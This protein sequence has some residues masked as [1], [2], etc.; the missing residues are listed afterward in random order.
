MT[1]PAR[2]RALLQRIFFWHGQGHAASSE[3]VP[4]PA[5]DHALVLAARPQPAVPKWRQLRYVTRVLNLKERRLLVAMAA[6]F[7]VAVVS[8][9]WLLVQTRMVAT[10]APGGRI[11][12]AIIGAPK[13]PHPFYASTN[14]PDQDLV[15]LV[16]AGLFRRVGGS[17]VEPDLAERFEWSDGGKKLTV[18]LR[19]DAR[20]HDGA[21]LTTDDVLFTLAAA[22]D[23]AWRS[24]FVN[25]LRTMTME[26][27]DDRTLTLTFD[28]ADT[29]ILDT[30]TLGILPA[31]IWQD[32][33]PGSAHLADAN[34]RPIGAGP[35]RVRSFLKDGR[36]TIL[37]YT[38]ERNTQYH[39]LKAYLDQIELRFFPS[40]AEAEEALR[41]GQVDTLAFVPGPS[42]EDLTKH[43]RLDASVLELPQE[44]IA[45]LNVND[46]LLKEPKIRQAL[47]LVTE[48]DEIVTAQA[49]ISSPVNGP[50]PFLAFSA[51]SST[52][53]ERLEHARGLLE[54][55][56]W[57][58]VEGR[59][60]RVRSSSSTSTADLP[61][62]TFT[63]T[64]PDVPDLVAVSETLKRRWGLLSANVN[65]QVEPAEP[66]ARRVTADR[67]AQILVWNVL[68][69]PSQDQYPVWWSGEATGRGLNLSNLADRNVDDAIEAIRAATTTEMLETA[70]AA[71][72]QT[73]L[74]RFPAVF[75]TRPGYGYVHNTRLKGMTDRLQLGRPSDRFND[76]V[77]WYV[78]TARK[79]K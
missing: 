48:R 45:F 22:K 76:I 35:F 26:R 18:T 24:P 66:L 79:W 71:F 70:R 36:G 37:A 31:H 27:V 54:S 38:L 13:Y 40:R 34:T 78:N 23:P 49:G 28:R 42:I 63:I 39:G 58:K 11:V 20:F 9:I 17:N 64:V 10:P 77:H 7:A 51:P 25:A 4:E 55:A 32:I 74:A 21:P 56:G 33:L 44:T 2:L 75:L 67:N 57:K 59:E 1:L 43:K 61:E 14:D 68:L 46:P 16:Y 53:E 50:F 12:E 30:L 62:L 69:S 73:V 19:E 47:T 8:T 5:H 6:I 41:S 65:L 72:T 52:P 15:T 60:V 29:G 3:F